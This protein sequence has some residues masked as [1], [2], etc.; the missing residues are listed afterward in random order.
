[1]LSLDVTASTPSLDEKTRPIW[2]RSRMSTCGR[3]ET[4][5][6]R[7]C[8]GTHTHTHVR[9]KNGAAAAVSCKKQANTKGA[10]VGV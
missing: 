3:S 8:D 7:T 4:V 5:R 1:M 2:C 6:V 9:A 10:A